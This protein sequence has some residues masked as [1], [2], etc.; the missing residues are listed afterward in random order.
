MFHLGKDD[1]AF[2]FQLFLPKPHCLHSA[3]GQWEKA[4][5]K[6]VHSH[7][8]DRQCNL[9]LLQTDFWRRWKFS[10]DED[11]TD[12]KSSRLKEPWGQKVDGMGHI[13]RTGVSP[14]VLGILLLGQMSERINL[15]GHISFQRFQFVVSW[16]WAWDKAKIHV[17]RPQERKIA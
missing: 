4:N 10:T 16:L 8:N 13:W 12:N 9:E 14:A 3:E 5:G 6:G 17:S 2:F 15:Q 11:E 1:Y 7:R